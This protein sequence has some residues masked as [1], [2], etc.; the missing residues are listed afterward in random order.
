MLPAEFIQQQQQQLN[1]TKASRDAMQ[2]VVQILTQRALLQAQLV[3]QQ[4]LS[5]VGCVNSD[6]L[7]PDDI[8]EDMQVT[9]T[10]E[11]ALVLFADEEIPVDCSVDQ[12]LLSLEESETSSE[13]SSD[14]GSDD[15]GYSVAR[16]VFSARVV[17]GAVSGAGIPASSL[18]ELRDDLHSNTCRGQNHTPC[19]QTLSSLGQH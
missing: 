19:T 13:T 3:Q 11:D 17:S 16:V 10:D 18:D 6:L 15:D 14:L 2:R 1:M 12:S 4:D 7:M 8:S 9:D 5:V